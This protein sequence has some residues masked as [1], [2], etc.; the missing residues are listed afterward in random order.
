MLIHSHATIQ[1]D[2]FYMIIC[3]N[4]SHGANQRLQQE[5]KGGKT[6]PG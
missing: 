3:G 6:G 1:P 2:V 5:P 4:G